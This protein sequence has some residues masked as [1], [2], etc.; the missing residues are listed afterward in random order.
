MQHAQGKKTFSPN[1]N[2]SPSHLCPPQ[3]QNQPTK[4][5]FLPLLAVP[6]RY[7]GVLLTPKMFLASLK[8][9]GLASPGMNTALQLAA[10]EKE[11]PCLA[12]SPCA[13][14]SARC[15]SGALSE[16]GSFR[17]VSLLLS[18]FLRVSWCVRMAL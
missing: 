10:A 6:I 12:A 17:T 18:S 5:D 15:A 16:M 14:S 7:S 8:T 1:E 13:G 9:A 2:F 3:L 11:G 4:L